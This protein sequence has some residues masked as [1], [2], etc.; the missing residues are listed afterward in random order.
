MLRSLYS[1]IS[2]LRNEQIAMDVIGNNIANVNTVGFKAGRVTFE[3]AMSQLLEG[4]TRPESEKAGGTNPLE[5]GLGANV[6][7][8]NTLLTQGALQTTGQVTDLAIQGND[9]FAYSNGVG[10]VYSRSGELQFDAEGNFVSS[11]NGYK[12]QGMIAA[13]DGSYPPGTKIGDITIP[14]GEKAPAR[15]TTEVKYQCNLDSDSN[16]LGTVT[17]SNQFFAALNTAAAGTQTLTSLYDSNGHSLGIKEGDVISIS[18]NGVATRQFVVGQGTG[19]IWTLGGATGSLQ[20]ALTAYL[21]NNGAGPSPGALV[22]INANGQLEINNSAGTAFSGLQITS[23]RPGS[24]SYVANAFTFPPAITAGAGSVFDSQVILRPAVSTD[25]LGNVM[26]AT[27]Q[28]LG[29]ENGDVI[30]IN[31]TVGGKAINE[32]D[33]TYAN[34]ASTTPTTVGNIINAIQQAFSLPATDSTLNNNPSVSINSADTENDN[35]PDGS[36]VIRG[37]PELAFALTGVSVSASNS[38]NVPPSPI[39]FVAN[40][41]FTEIQDARD[42]GVHNAS[43][44]VYD[45]SGDAHTLVLTFTHSRIPNDWFWEV[46]TEGGE[47]ILGGNTGHIT[48]GQDGSPSTFTSDDGSTT[49]RFDPMNGSNIVSIRLNTGNPGTFTGVTQFRSETTTIAKSQDGYPMGKL[50][51][52][53]ID[54]RGE[55]YGVYTNGVSKSVARIYVAQFN[56]PAGLLKLGDSMYA[57]SNNSGEAVMQQ[58]GV[59]STSTIKPGAIEMSNVDLAAEFTN[60]ITTQRAYQANARVITASDSLLQELVQLVR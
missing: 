58:P 39:R 12:L 19:E 30:R 16:A 26:D 41:A 27:G 53:S 2:G 25:L 34:P 33:I 37:Q 1:S 28:P 48:F 38:N 40:M 4:A 47:Q 3:E 46:T 54:E 15:A 35:L 29:F 14:F 42:V 51:K 9:Y 50:Q 59:G 24:S 5:I 43:I 23:S 17:H 7:S 57:V 55:I 13:T 32:V 21:N 49:L 45:S 10:T 31:G 11:Y 22:S 6:G 18:V 36:I 8:I 60:M 56:N 44:Q 52:I 20:S